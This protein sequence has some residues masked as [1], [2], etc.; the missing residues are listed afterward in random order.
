MLG[1]VPA[2]NASSWTSRR[3]VTKLNEAA[4]TS[5]PLNPSEMPLW[6]GVAVA[7]GVAVGSGVLVGRAVGVGVCVGVAVAPAGGVGVAVGIPPPPPMPPIGQVPGVEAQRPKMG[8]GLGL[9]LR[10]TP[11]FGLRSSQ[12]CESTRYPGSITRLSNLVLQPLLLVIVTLAHVDVHPVVMVS[13]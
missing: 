10:R 7:V 11:R 5:A 12:H 13:A 6:V 3:G 2:L 9:T 1:V 4:L 8:T